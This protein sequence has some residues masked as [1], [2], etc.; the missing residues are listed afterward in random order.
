METSNKRFFSYSV[1][2]GQ[3]M[4]VFKFLIFI[5]N[6]NFVLKIFQHYFLKVLVTK[7]FIFNELINL[8]PDESFTIKPFK[9]RKIMSIKMQKKFSWPLTLFNNTKITRIRYNNI[10]SNMTYVFS[11]NIYS[12][13]I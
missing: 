12:I 10:K 1:I 9:I 2:D 7:I 4:F 3:K 5:E 6:E 13:L 11:K 8:S